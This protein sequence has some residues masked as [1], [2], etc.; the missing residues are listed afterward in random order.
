MKLASSH[1]QELRG[2][3]LVE[4]RRDGR[5]IFYRVADNDV[6]KLLVSLR[7]LAEQRLANVQETLQGYAHSREN[8]TTLGRRELIEKAE[9]GEVIVIDVRP[10]DEFEAGHLPNARSEP[11]AELKKMIGKLPK[12][13]EIVVYCRGAYCILSRDAVNSLRRKGYRATQLSEGISE[14]I[15]AGVRLVRGC[16]NSDERT[17]P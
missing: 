4:T 9:S 10:R 5:F 8:M 6:V 2:A 3:R 1:L 7:L 17:S 12:S 11:I 16:K 13:K 14:W 15:A